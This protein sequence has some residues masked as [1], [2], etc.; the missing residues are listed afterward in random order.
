M[1]AKIF[2]VGMT[3]SRLLKALADQ[4]R[5]WMTTLPK[6]PVLISLVCTFSCIVTHVVQMPFVN[7]CL[8]SSKQASAPVF[9]LRAFILV[10]LHSR[11]FNQIHQRAL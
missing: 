9:F 6:L 1:S 5:C 10:T 3:S 4:H 8:M 11:I 7:P 2:L